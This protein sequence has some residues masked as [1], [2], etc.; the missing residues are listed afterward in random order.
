MQGVLWS[1][2]RVR[3]WHGRSD[4]YHLW[5][6]KSQSPQIIIKVTSEYWTWEFVLFL[7]YM[8]NHCC[9]ESEDKLQPSL[10]LVRRAISTFHMLL[11]H[12][13]NSQ[14]NHQQRFGDRRSKIVIWHVSILH[15][16]INRDFHRFCRCWQFPIHF[17][18]F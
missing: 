6:F 16:S 10:L 9:F 3:P 1:R 8:F 4:L 7:D 2:T 13:R 5:I 15:C 17:W 11:G 14:K 18:W 12:E